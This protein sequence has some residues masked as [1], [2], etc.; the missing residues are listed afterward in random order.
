MKKRFSI[1]LFFLALVLFGWFLFQSLNPKEKEDV[2]LALGTKQSIVEKTTSTKEPELNAEE[3]ELLEKFTPEEVEN[4]KYSHKAAQAANQNV[5][6]YG[7]CLD[8]D[9]N[10]IEGVRVQ[11]K[12]TKMRKSM[13]SVVVTESFK[14]YDQ[15]E[16]VTDKDGRFEFIDKGSYLLLEQIK[17][18][19]YMD[20][21]GPESFGY[22]F[23]QIL[24]GNTM[25]GMHKANPLKPIIFTM[26][27]KGEG[28]TAM[29]LH[30]KN[31]YKSEI[32][33][34]KSDMGTVA[35]FDLSKRSKTGA[36]TGNTIEVTALNE[37]NRHRDPISRKIVGSRFHAWSY[38]L[39]IPEGGLV[40]TDDIFLFRPPETGYEESFNFA[41]PEGEDGWIGQVEAQKFYFKTTDGNYGAFILNVRATADGGMG[42]RFKKLFFNP[43][44]ERNLEN[45]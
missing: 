7:Q 28:S 16:T 13:L 35:Y 10:P 39:R 20:A 21:R 32:G 23:G 26:W 38:T 8:Q 34:Q 3:K 19:G 11:A 4:L 33:M 43:T 42:F 25:A 27:K 22:R 9:N 45:F 6:F 1:T 18:S 2:P 44:G 15:L 5:T 24:T 40:Q 12:L 31:G 36:S 17:R 14:Y 37:G 41:V 30:D 29:Q